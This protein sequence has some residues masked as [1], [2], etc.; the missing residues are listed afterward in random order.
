MLDGLC[1]EDKDCEEDK[2]VVSGHGRT[3]L[4]VKVQHSSLVTKQI[5]VQVEYSSFKKIHINS[6]DEKLYEKLFELYKFRVR[7]PLEVVAP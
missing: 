4:S 3:F 1:Q 5:I 6:S 7:W 2:L